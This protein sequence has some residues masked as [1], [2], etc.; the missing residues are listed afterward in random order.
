MLFNRHPFDS[1]PHPA[2]RFTCSFAYSPH[3]LARTAPLHPPPHHSSSFH[4]APPRP[5]PHRPAP[6]H[7]LLD[8]DS[9]TAGT[10]VVR[11]PGAGSCGDGGYQ[12]D[13]S[14]TYWG[15]LCHRFQASCSTIAVGGKCMMRE[16]GGVQMPGY[17]LGQN[18]A[19]NGEAT[20]DFKASP[21]GAP[22]AIF[23]DLGTNDMRAITTLGPV[24]GPAGFIAQTVQFMVNASTLYG[25]QVRVFTYVLQ[26]RCTYVLQY[27]YLL[28]CYYTMRVYVRVTTST[29]LYY[30]TQW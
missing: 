3:S 1:Y 16:C 6:L 4:P 22:D 25:A 30:T 18:Y 27:T 12:S 20:F 15:R 11:P 17:Y 2:V 13:G 29:T 5:A 19:D 23:I 21:G 26:R 7:S 28:T 9:I 14:Q 24:D 10:N 8:Q